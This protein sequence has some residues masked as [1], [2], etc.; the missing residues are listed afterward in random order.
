MGLV[1]FSSFI[2]YTFFI[3]HGLFDKT[4]TLSARLTASAISCVIK[5]AVFFIPLMI[6]GFSIFKVYASN[7]DFIIIAEDSNGNRVP[8][9]L[10][11][12]Y[13]KPSKVEASAAVK[14]SANGG[15]FFDGST[16]LYIKIPPEGSSLQDVFVLSDEEMKYF[17]FNLFFAYREYYIPQISNLISGEPVEYHDGDEILIDW[18][19]DENA[20]LVTIDTNGGSFEFP[21]FGSFPITNI[22]TYQQYLDM[23]LTQAAYT[24]PDYSAYGY[25][26]NPS[27]SHYDNNLE[28]DYSENISD[29][30]YVCYGPV[31]NINGVLISYDSGM[32]WGEWVDSDYNTHGWEL[33]ND[34]G[35][36]Y[37]NT[38]AVACSSYSIIHFYNTL[39]ENGNIVNASDVINPHTKYNIQ[40]KHISYSNSSGYGQLYNGSVSC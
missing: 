31:L 16:E 13:A 24:H 26:D 19:Y 21:N 12:I 10:L 27:C 14:I 18:E 15:H 2:S 23:F 4:I 25:D 9:V 40:L 11:D 36:I 39:E 35:L 28:W 37:S 8:G 5:I 34:L 6:I 29:K 33:H 38:Y 3:V 30:M 17:A 22:T 32:T 7:G 20:T 1:L